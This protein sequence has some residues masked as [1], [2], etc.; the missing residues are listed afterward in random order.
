MESY[1]LTKR[2]MTFQR[3]TRSYIP[4]DSVLQPQEIPIDVDVS[5]F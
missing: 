4:E 5:I 3:T 1:V 2:R